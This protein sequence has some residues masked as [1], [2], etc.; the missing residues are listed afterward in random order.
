MGR[1]KLYPY[2]VDKENTELD[3]KDRPTPESIANWESMHREYWQGP[4][5]N[6]KINKSTEHLSDEEKCRI[7]RNRFHQLNYRIRKNV[8]KLKSLEV[9]KDKTYSVLEDINLLKSKIE[10]DE[11][12]LNELK[13]TAKRP[14]LKTYK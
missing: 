5:L 1:Y 4:K 2:A 11:K 9:L 13:I 7:N 6:H 10:R 3:L 8:K 14:Y 12:N